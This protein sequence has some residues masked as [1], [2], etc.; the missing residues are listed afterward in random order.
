VSE[1]SSP[2]TPGATTPTTPENEVEHAVPEPGDDNGVDVPDENEV[3]APPAALPDGQQTFTSV[4]GS[5]TVVISSGSISL[6]TASPAAGFSSEVHDNG[7]TRVEVRFSSGD[8][9]WRIRVEV[10]PGGLTSEITD[11]G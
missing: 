10:G 9:E 3:E 1:T 6:G 11:H 5:I 8:T 7:P 4:G 2:S